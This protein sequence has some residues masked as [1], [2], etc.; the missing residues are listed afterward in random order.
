MQCFQ[1]DQGCEVIL[2]CF[3]STLRFSVHSLWRANTWK[4]H[5]CKTPPSPNCPQNSLVIE[6]TD[7]FVSYSVLIFALTLAAIMASYRL[8][9]Q[10]IF[11]L[12]NDSRFRGLLVSR[13][14]IFQLSFSTF[15]SKCY[16]LKSWSKNR[17][18]FYFFKLWALKWA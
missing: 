10:A 9:R 7:I 13:H 5:L 14:P 15:F 17:N 18:I 11:I 2:G 1:L 16:T 4:S 8:G 12:S 3:C 6:F